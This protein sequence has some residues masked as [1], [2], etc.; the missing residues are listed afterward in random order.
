M[1]TSWFAGAVFAV[2]AVP[3]LA[4]DAEVGKEYEITIQ[5]EQDNQYTGPNGQAKIGGI[6]FMIPNAKVMEKYKVKVT[7]IREN[8]HTMAKQASCDFEQIGGTKKGNCIGA[9]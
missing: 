5:T 1:S 3:V 8:Q 2:L 4:Q 6:V 9:P 7:E